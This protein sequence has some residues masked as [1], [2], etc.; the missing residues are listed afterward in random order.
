M[1]Q[2]GNKSLLAYKKSKIHLQ[3]TYNTAQH[4]HKKGGC[5]IREVAEETHKTK[6]MF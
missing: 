1:E 2:I 6:F 5:N 4:T 3:G